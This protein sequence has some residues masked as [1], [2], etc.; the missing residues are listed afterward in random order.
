[1]DIATLLV[2]VL[3][4]MLLGDGGYGR[5]RWYGATSFEVG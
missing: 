4:V 3:I 1:M 5:G 2:I